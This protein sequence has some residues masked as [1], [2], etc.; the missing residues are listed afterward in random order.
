MTRIL[1]VG[2]VIESLLN[3][4]G[5]VPCIMFPYEALSITMP[6]HAGDI[7]ASAVQL[8][9]G[10]AMLGLGLTYPLLTL[11]PNSPGVFYKRKI[12]FETFAVAELGLM[13]LML[14]LS[15]KEEQEGGFT[16]RGLLFSAFQVVPTLAWH[17]AVVWL[18]PGLMKETDYNLVEDQ[19]KF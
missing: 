11:I 14:W 9:Q 8:L 10:Y 13:V 6:N 17:A 16:S 1:K 18:W 3:V 5:G 15:T 4:I 7:P 12:I 19:K 2:L